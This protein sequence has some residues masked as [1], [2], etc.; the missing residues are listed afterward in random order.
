MVLSLD[1][2]RSADG[3]I[4]IFKQGGHEWASSI[5]ALPWQAISD[6][7]G[8]VM[9]KSIERDGTGIGLDM[10]SLEFVPEELRMPI[11]LSGGVGKPEHL[12]E[13]LMSPRVSGVATANLLNFVGDSM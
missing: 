2:A 1:W 3:G 10:A 4:Q 12:I 11:I 7:F 5:E 6:V 13:G 8:E 9:L